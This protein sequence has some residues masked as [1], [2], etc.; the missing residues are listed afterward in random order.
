MHTKIGA[1]HADLHANNATVY[2]CGATHIRQG[3]QKHSSRLSSSPLL[4]LPP[5]LEERQILMCSRSLAPWA[6]SLISADLS[7]GLVAWRTRAQWNK[8]AKAYA[9]N[10]LR[11]QVSR[12]L[13]AFHRSA[14][15]F[16]EK[17]QEALKAAILANP[18][19]VFRVLTYT[20]FMSI[21]RGLGEMLVAKVEGIGAKHFA[22]PA[23]LRAFAKHI[24][25][26]SRDALVTYMKDLVDANVEASR[27]PYAGESLLPK[28][29]AEYKYSA[30]DTAALR[31][32]DLVD[33][34]NYN[35]PLKWS[36]EDYKTSLPG[37]ESTSWRSIWGG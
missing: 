6:V 27:I 16:T 15:T 11:D 29:F 5:D 21:G 32:G 13:R 19:A 24:E 35:N 2:R 18:E 14:P 7:S 25:S 36:G 22:P 9:Q 4:H 31:R 34:Y 37:P 17:N 1:I 33:A 10:F 12:V 28:L 20:D 23:E 26:A 3:E 8:I 30:W